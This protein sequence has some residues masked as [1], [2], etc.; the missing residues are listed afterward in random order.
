MTA[1]DLRVVI[2]E[3]EPASRTV[4]RGLLAARPGVTVCAEAGDGAAAIDAIRIWRP[5]LV[6][7]DIQLPDLD[8]FE[9]LRR[10]APVHAPHVVFVTAYDEF[11]VRAFEVDALD[12][13]V[14]PFT[15]G[16]FDR[17]FERALAR[18][19]EGPGAPRALGDLNGVA[20]PA[21]DAAPPG[22]FLVRVGRRSLLVGLNEVTW[23]EADGYYAA[24]H[25]GAHTHL[26]SET[27]AA[28]EARLDPSRFVRIHRSAIVN[29]G[30]V[31][32]LRRDSSGALEVIL[33]DGTP[34]EVS[35]S[36]RRPLA[37]RLARRG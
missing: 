34:L 20:D 3:D 37:Q 33:F 1:R 25:V 10:V 29:L 18:I 15:D 30:F 28:L 13:L 2:V 4:L 11:A 9:V 17:T 7:L 5:D 26:V 36:R 27:M 35:R 22:H 24:I 8:G 23:I 21:Q 31:R 32:E 6:F 16:R 12:Y 14:K 19:G